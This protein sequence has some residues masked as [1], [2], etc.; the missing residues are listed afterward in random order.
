MGI[1]KAISNATTSTLTDQWKDIYVPCAFDEH[2]LVVPGVLKV[3]NT[4]S[5]NS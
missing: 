2:M 1:F 3:K 4:G 5:T